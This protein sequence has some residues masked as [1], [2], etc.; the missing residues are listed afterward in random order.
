MPAA[1]QARLEDM[2]NRDYRDILGGLLLVIGGL[3]FALYSLA[4]YDLGTIRRMGPGMYPVGLGLLMIGLGFIISV[5][6]FFRS[7]PPIRIRIY[8]PIFV[9]S[10][11]AA[12]AL[13]IPRFG[14]IPAIVAQVV[15][16]SLAERRFQP[17]GLAVLTLFLCALAYVVFVYLLGL[18]FHLFRWRP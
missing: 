7:G 18:P 4:T 5:P 1:T 6:A 2:L 17:K 11:L 13:V 8:S 14:L 3:V 9:L 15:V 10:G 12:F 16:S